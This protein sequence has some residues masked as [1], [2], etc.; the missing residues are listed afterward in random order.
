MCLAWH[1]LFPAEN[2]V[3]CQSGGDVGKKSVSQAVGFMSQLCLALREKKIIPSCLP[4]A[5]GELALLAARPRSMKL[6]VISN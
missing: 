4:T 6:V 2:A 3:S 5:W 1:M